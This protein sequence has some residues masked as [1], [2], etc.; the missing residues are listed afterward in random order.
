MTNPY[1]F[2][3]TLRVRFNETDFQGHV[4]FGWYLQYF[5]VAMI[6]YMRKLDYSYQQMRADNVDMFYV[7]A[8]VT[9]KSPA[10]FDELL[11]VHCCTGYIGNSS[12][13][14]DFQIFAE[15]DERLV[16]TGEITGVTAVPD[17]K[18]ALRVPDKLRTAVANYEEA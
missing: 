17:T 10:I 2:Y 18:E 12:V 7:D 15:S 1:R 14:F 4:N 13:R 5:D 6:E 11:R 16:A 8:H 9:Y 3:T